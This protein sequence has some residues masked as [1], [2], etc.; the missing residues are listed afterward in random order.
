MFRARK[1][2][3]CHL[4]LFEHQKLSWRYVTDSD[5]RATLLSCQKQSSTNSHSSVCG[6]N[7]L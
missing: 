2:I 5:Y 6:R 7:D 3:V 4:G 1:M